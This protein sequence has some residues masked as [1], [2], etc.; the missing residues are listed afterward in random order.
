VE[1]FDEC[2]F[3]FTQAAA[4][5]RAKGAHL[6]TSAEMRAAMA[7]GASSPPGGSIYI[8]DWMADQVADDEAVYVS[9]A[10]ADNPDNQRGTSSSSWARCCLNVE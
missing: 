3:N 6:C 8:L 5:C 2:C 10:N 1:T 9:V 7:L 4:Q